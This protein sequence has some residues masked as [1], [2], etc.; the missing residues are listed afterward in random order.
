MD[1]FV[2]SASCE[3]KKLKVSY[4][5]GF[6]YFTYGEIFNYYSVT[7]GAMAAFLFCFFQLRCS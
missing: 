7:L 6:V 2:T 3:E 5:I 1:F 4:F